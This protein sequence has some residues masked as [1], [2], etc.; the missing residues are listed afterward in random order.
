MLA[1]RGLSTSSL[2]TARPA[3]VASRSS[4]RSAARPARLSRSMVARASAEKF[5]TGYEQKFGNAWILHGGLAMWSAVVCTPI[6]PLVNY[7]G[8]PLGIAFMHSIFRLMDQFPTGPKID[9]PF[10]LQLIVW[11]FGLFTVLTLGTIGVQGK[12]Q[13]YW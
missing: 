5:D 3:S 8:E 11:H 1:A 13:N 6:V 10:W 9:D 7:Q 2:R 4:V 12:K